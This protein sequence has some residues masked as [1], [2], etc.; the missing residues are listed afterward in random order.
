MDPKNFTWKYVSARSKA[1]VVLVSLLL[2]GTALTAASA[3]GV[4]AA[5][6]LV[7]NLNP[8]PYTPNPKP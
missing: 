2:V 1:L 3:V 6:M 7:L 4:V 5:V 8:K